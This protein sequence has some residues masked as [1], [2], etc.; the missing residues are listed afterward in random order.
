MSSFRVNMKRNISKW[1]RAIRLPTLT[2]SVIP[3][4]LG[5]MLAFKENS[6]HPFSFLLAVLAM[7]FFQIASNL[8]NDVDDFR[9]KVDTKKSFGSSRV[10]VDD[11]LTQ[12]QVLIAAAIIFGAGIAIGIYLTVISSV[13]IL[14]LGALGA[15]SAYFYTRKP[16][17]F[18]YRGFGVP[19]IFLMFGPLPV[20][21]SYY[22]STGMYSLKPLLVSIPVGLLTTA[23]L[24]ANDLRDIEH[25][26]RAN[27]KSF[28]MALGAENAR[29]FYLGLLATSYLTILLLVFADQLTAL[30][31]INFLTVPLAVMLIRQSKS[32][33]E[34]RNLDHKTAGLQLVFGVLLL[35][36][37][38]L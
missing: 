15:G 13:V 7:T 36:S 10:I 5:G 25:D 23:I 17:C 26:E 2:A 21:G 27:I 35:I 1:L 20:F 37:I 9:N 8:L 19:L 12:R 3:V 18:K 24:H 38:I 33:V 29:H 34:C 6:F 28:A 30:S 4:A 11:L 16:F 32:E 22:L 31:L 14:L